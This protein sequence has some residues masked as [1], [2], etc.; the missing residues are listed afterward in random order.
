M[1]LLPA[2]PL[3]RFTPAF[4]GL[5]D[6]PAALAEQRSGAVDKVFLAPYGVRAATTTR[7]LTSQPAMIARLQGLIIAVSP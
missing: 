1:G 3:D 2:L 4:F 7:R 5:A 6:L